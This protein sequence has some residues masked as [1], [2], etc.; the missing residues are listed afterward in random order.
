MG[1]INTNL[2]YLSTYGYHIE[3]RNPDM[4]SPKTKVQYFFFC[5]PHYKVHRNKAVSMGLYGNLQYKLGYYRHM[6]PI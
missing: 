6:R 4:V 1:T 5:Q 3:S 2:S